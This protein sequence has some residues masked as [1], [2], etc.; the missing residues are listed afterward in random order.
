VCIVVSHIEVN[1]LSEKNAEA[2]D[3]SETNACFEIIFVK[4]LKLETKVAFRMQLNFTLR[5]M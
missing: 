2:N 1:D 3:L 4:T 5:F